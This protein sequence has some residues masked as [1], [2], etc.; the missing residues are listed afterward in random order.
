M[1]KAAFKLSTNP[2]LGF[3][4]LFQSALIRVYRGKTLLISPRLRVSA[5]NVPLPARPV[6]RDRQREHSFTARP[7]RPIGELQHAAVGFSDLAAQDQT[8]AAAAVLG[9]EEWNKKIVTVEQAG[10]LVADEDF[11]AARVGAP[12]YFNRAGMFERG[13]KRSVDGVADQVDQHL[14]NLVGVGLDDY[15][16]AVDRS[17]PKTALQRCRALH[18]GAN[19]DARTSGCGHA[20]KPRVCLHKSVE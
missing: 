19:I 16:R 17:D 2:Q 10:A 3:E 11:N 13:I 8:D 1:E 6:I 14:L 4:G 18:Q 15:K 20:R 5:V 7:V 12:A 9:G